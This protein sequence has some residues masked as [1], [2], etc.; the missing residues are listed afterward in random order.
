MNIAT[1][2]KYAEGKAPFLGVP[3]FSL[4]VG[5]YVTAVFSRRIL[6]A[7]AS[8]PHITK[9]SFDE[10]EECLVLNGSPRACYRLKALREPAYFV[11]DANEA[12]ARTRR[13]TNITRGLPVNERKA[14][15]LEAEA[16][17]LTRKLAKIRDTR[18]VHPLILCDW[19]RTPATD[20]ERIR[21]QNWHDDKGKRR[22]L[23]WLAH[24]ARSTWKQFYADVEAIT[25]YPVSDSCRH[26]RVCKRKDGPHIVDYLKHLNEHVMGMTR[27]PWRS[28]WKTE[29]QREREGFERHREWRMEYLAAMAERRALEDQIGLLREEVE[30]LRGGAV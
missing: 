17:V 27:K 24:R 15:K 28:D 5:R 19:H 26:D 14:A 23:G 9:V 12:W 4:T 21:E 30:S 13:K 16:G 10:E 3:V 20:S 6:Q 22:R 7:A 18:P 1:V 29:G 8:C 25:G 11:K 2:R